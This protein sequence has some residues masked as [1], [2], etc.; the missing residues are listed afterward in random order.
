MLCDGGSM[1]RRE[2]DEREIALLGSSDS[3][4]LGRHL[5]GELELMGVIVYTSKQLCELLNISDNT[6]RSIM[7][8]YGFRTGNKPKSPLRIT[9]EQLTK[10]A[11]DMKRKGE[12][13]ESFP[14][15]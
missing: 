11:E 13:N 1:K 8:E 6:A 2:R 15:Q 14:N 10:Y 3:G 12:T 9:E 4:L 5:V 7:Q